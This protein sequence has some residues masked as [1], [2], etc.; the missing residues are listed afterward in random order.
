MTSLLALAVLLSSAEAGDPAPS[1]P[2]VQ[3]EAAAVIEYRHQAF[4][5][6]GKHMKVLSMAAKGRVT[7][8][9]KDLVMHAKALARA[10]QVMEGWFPAGTGAGKESRSEALSEVWTNASG[11]KEAVGAFQGATTALV[12]VAEANDTAGLLP[13]F[14]KVGASCGGCHDTFRKDDDG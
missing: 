8:P 4:Q 2:A 1:P 7:L 5:G 13:A 11:F 3:G 6:M 10:S 9:T 12:T 14:K